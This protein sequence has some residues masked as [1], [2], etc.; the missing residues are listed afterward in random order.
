VFD[1]VPRDALFQRLRDI[2]ISETLLVAIMRL[3]ESVLGRLRMAHGLS[4]F[5]QSTIGVKQGCPLSPT[6]FGIY[7]DELESFLHE[8]IQEGDGC[9]LHQVLISLLL[10][11]DDLVLLASTPEGLQRQIDALASF[12]DLR[13]LMVNLGK[14]KVLIFNASKSSLTDLHFYYRGAEI[15]I[16]TTYT[17][18][19]VQFTGP[20][21]R[22]AAG[23]STSTQ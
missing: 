15:E 14:T 2:G 1:T 13:Q 11:A 17:Y 8:H 19:G 22:Y 4:D 10:F 3:Y 21:F 18:L 23:P 12:C 7:I 9:L 20:R 6:L 5:I 16:T